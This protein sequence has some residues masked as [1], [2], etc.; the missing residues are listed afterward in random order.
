MGDFGCCID[1]SKEKPKSFVGTAQYLCPE[2]LKDPKTASPASDYWSIG[3]TLYFFVCGFFPFKGK[4]EYLVMKCVEKGEFTFPD[5]LTDEN[6]KDL[7]SKFLV[8]DPNQR[9]SHFESV[10]EHPYFNSIVW[11]DLFNQKAPHP[12]NIRD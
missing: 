2:I 11:D 9:L 7:I 1:V 5:F 3:C 12:Q 6:I 10:Q 8:S 4:S